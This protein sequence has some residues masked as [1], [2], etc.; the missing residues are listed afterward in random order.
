MRRLL[1]LRPRG[2]GRLLLGLLPLLVVALLYLGASAARHI[3]NPHD[4]TLP[5]PTAMV[6]AA[7][8]MAS[9]PAPLLADTAASLRRMTIAVTLSAALALV[10]GLTLGLVPLARAGLAPSMAAVAAVPSL[11]ALP[12]L[13]VASGPG[14]TAAIALIVIG[15]APLMTRDLAACVGAIPEEQIVKAQ[16]LGASTLQTALQ[17]ALPQALPG[18]IEGVRRS[19]PLAWVLLIAAEAIA[20][21]VGLG[22]RIFLAHAEPAMDVILPYVAW[23]TILA[24]SLDIGLSALSRRAFP[25]AHP[26]GIG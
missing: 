6:S 20:A 18:L 7:V 21:D 19:L 1:N 5:T 23:I 10:G 14:E 8:D 3:D 4:R 17:L 16:S 15:I 9:G 22:H 25:W 12:I 11:A 13:F 2:G 24:T 26:Q